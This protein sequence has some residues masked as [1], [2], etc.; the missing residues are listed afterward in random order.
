VIAGAFAWLAVMAAML[1]AYPAAPAWLV[2]LS[3]VYP[4]FY[5]LLSLRLASAA[6]RHGPGPEPGAVR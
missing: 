3:L 2:A 5:V 1:P 4:A 6:T